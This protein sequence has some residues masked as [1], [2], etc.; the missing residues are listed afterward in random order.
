M[1]NGA[2]L[3]FA[4]DGEV[5]GLPPDPTVAGAASAKAYVDAKVS[6]SV[7]SSASDYLRK[8][9]VKKSLSITGSDTAS[10]TAT[11]ASAPTGMTATTET[12]FVFFINGQYM[13]HDALEVEQK[14]NVLFHLKIDTDSIGY[15][16]EETDEIIA[17]GKF[18]S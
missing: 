2:N 15:E 18:N 11:T 16:L 17:H 5:L 3:T 7:T 9:F 1:A 10:F 8:N 13:E 4:S 14:T 6:G 12:D